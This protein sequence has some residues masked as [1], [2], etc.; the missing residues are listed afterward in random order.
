MA[1]LGRYAALMLGVAITFGG[2]AAT[3][4]FGV[5]AFLGMPLLAL[6]LGVLSAAIDA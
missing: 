2:L 5:F 1:A 3:L 4:S 6:G